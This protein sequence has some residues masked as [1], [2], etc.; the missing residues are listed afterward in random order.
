MKS[1]FF[2]IQVDESTDVAYFAVLLVTARYL[3][4]N[5]VEN[6]LLCHPLSKCT[7][8]KDIMNASA[9]RKGH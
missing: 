3:K 7:I 2:A 9:K 1:K 6:L 8:G 4:G 5:E